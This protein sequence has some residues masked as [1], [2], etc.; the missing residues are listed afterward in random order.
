VLRTWI[1]FGM[2]FLNC[3]KS[4]IIETIQFTQMTSYLKLC[5]LSTLVK[6]SCTLRTTSPSK[7]TSKETSLAKV[8]S[9]QMSVESAQPGHMS[10]RTFCIPSLVSKS[11]SFWE[12]THS[13]KGS[14]SSNQSKP[15]RGCLRNS[16][17]CLFKGIACME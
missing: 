1:L 5:S 8:K 11:T 13:S 14:F 17:R 4:D 7:L 2:W 6:S 10:W 16:H 15:L 9:S 12:N 3:K